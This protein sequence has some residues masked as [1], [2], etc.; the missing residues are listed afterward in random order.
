MKKKI[1]IFI[2]IFDFFLGLFFAAAWF[3]SSVLLHPPNAK[4]FVCKPAIFIN[5]ENPKKEFGL[6]FEDVEF[7]TSDGFKIS[8]WYVPSKTKSNKAVI[9]VHGRASNR[10]EGL[11]YLPTIRSLGINVL[12]ID[13]RNSGKSDKSFRVNL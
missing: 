10:T 2:F 11:R 3:F 4:N 13:L 6:E 7:T 8:A 12:L 9:S 5:C 1:L